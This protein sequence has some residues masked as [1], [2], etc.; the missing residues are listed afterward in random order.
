MRLLQRFLGEGGEGE[1]IQPWIEACAAAGKKVSDLEI[2]R[3]LDLGRAQPLLRESI[4]AIIGA[5][6]GWLATHQ[7]AWAWATA[8]ASPGD[9]ST[10]TG[11][12]RL[13]LLRHVR[14]TDP[15]AARQLI[16]STWSED[17]PAD[18]AAFLTVLKHGL[19]L[20]DEPLL[21]RALDDRRKEVRQIALD[22]G[23]ALPGSAISKRCQERLANCWAWTRKLLSKRLE[24]TPPATYDKTW[25][26]DGI[27]AKPPTGIGE[28]AWWLQQLVGGVPAIHWSTAWDI[29]PA[30]ALAALAKTDWE[31]PFV[32]GLIASSHAQPDARWIEALTKHRLGA[33]HASQLMG[34]LGETER[35]RLL[36]GSLPARGKEGQEWIALV[37]DIDC[38][39]SPSFSQHVIKVMQQQ[40]SKDWIG[41]VYRLARRLAPISAAVLATLPHD[42][43]AK[44]A[45]DAALSILDLRRQIA[46]EFA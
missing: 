22:L 25:G 46:Q 37:A 30:E 2:P 20:A 29:E 14:Q 39:W 26:R 16:E 42:D 3:L 23:H 17:A 5:R 24:V 43:G 36:G 41:Y 40:P 38:H 12:E 18:R 32:L 27:E 11:Q 21:E 35:E 7:E 31:E 13:A 45:L 10:S 34:A 8:A 9:W 6:G 28:R 4:R 33:N 44:P 19:A 15:A 1:L